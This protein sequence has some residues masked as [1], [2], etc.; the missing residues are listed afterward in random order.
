MQGRTGTQMGAQLPT[1]EVPDKKQNK[2]PRV[3]P[4]C[5]RATGLL[6]HPLS[7]ASYRR[8]TVSVKKC[9]LSCH[10]RNAVAHQIVAVLALPLEWA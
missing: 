8:H 3:V 9:A 4:P 1:Q 7:K 2:A 6:A 5:S 10:T